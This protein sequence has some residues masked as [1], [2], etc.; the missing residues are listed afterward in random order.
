MDFFA[1][2]FGS[3]IGVGWVATMGDWLDNAGPVGAMLAFG[4]GG[5]VMF[6]IGLCYA[7]LTSAM[8]VAG[9]EIAFSYR[10]FGLGKAAL[11]GWYLTLGYIAVS[12][13]EALAVGRVVGNL[14]PAT[15]SIELYEMQGRAVYLPHLLLGI[16][17][18]L[19]ITGLNYWGVKLAARFQL[20]LTAILIGAGLVFVFAAF[21]QGSLENIDPPFSETAAVGLLA[22]FVTT[23]LWFVGFDIIPQT[24]EESLPGFPPRRLGV[25]ILVAIA[26][27]TLFYVAVI[28]SVSLLVPW[29]ELTGEDLPTADAFRRAF[30]SPWLANLVLVAAIIGLLTSWNGFFLAATRVLFSLARARV[31]PQTFA[32]IHPKFGTPHRAVLLVGGVTLLSPFLGHQTIGAVIDVSSVCLAA[33]FFGACLSMWKLRRTAPD[34]ARPYR[35]PGGRGVALVAA[36]GALFILGALVVPGSGVSLDWEIEWPILIGWTLL[37]VVLWILAR[38]MRSAVTEEERAAAILQS[39]DDASAAGTPGGP[40]A[41]PGDRGCA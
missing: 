27:A 18:T 37:G 28:L 9:G 31:I 19:L 34:M 11:V 10:A 6:L 26:A 36:G 32:E 30:A 23:P 5:G 35:V 8:P 3:I 40:S 24:A 21:G 25:L 13:F 38:D 39:Q 33:A 12:A 4:L 41:P 15:N 2:A 22:V 14:V 17:G 1:V 29:Q 20:V 16:L 7:E